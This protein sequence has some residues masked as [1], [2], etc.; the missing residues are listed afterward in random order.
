M[1]IYILS[2]IPS[3]FLL[4][5]YISFLLAGQLYFHDSL[6]NNIYLDIYR[7]TQLI[8]PWGTKF[9]YIKLPAV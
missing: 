8:L 4:A 9:S 7:H 1:Y 2:V 3:C 6:V 5:I